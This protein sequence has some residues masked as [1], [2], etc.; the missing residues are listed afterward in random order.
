M[1]KFEK[2]CQENPLQAQA[3]GA[4][5]YLRRQK[6]K[7]HSYNKMLDLLGSIR[8]RDWPTIGL[9]IGLRAEHMDEIMMEAEREN[10]DSPKTDVVSDT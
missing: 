10:Y 1:T 4:T 3:I 2:W 6:R 9:G 7:G 5:N 8:F